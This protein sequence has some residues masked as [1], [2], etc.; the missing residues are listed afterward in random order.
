MDLKAVIKAMLFTPGNGGRWGLPLLFEGAPG[1]GKT[2]ILTEV[3]ASVGLHCEVVIASLREPADFLGLPVPDGD[4]AKYLPPAWAVRAAQAKHAVVFL[5]ELNTAPPA[6]QAALLR[7][8]NERAIGEMVLPPTVRF[9]AAQ[10]KTEDAAGGWDLAAPMAN[11]FG[12]LPWTSP[13]IQQWSSWLVA[14]SA[15]APLVAEAGNAA[16][17][18]E[19]ESVL[20]QWEKPFAMAKGLVAG[21]LR[22]RGD[23]LHK[24]PTSTDPTASKA[25][26]S[27]RT[28][29]MATRAMASA[30]VHKLAPTDEDDLI[31]AF[32][33]NGAAGELLTFRAAADLPDP[34]DL[35]DGKIK[36]EHDPRRLDRTCAV[37]S[38]CAAL[39]SSPAA[40]KRDARAKAM[41]NLMGDVVTKH[42]DILVPATLALVDS[43]LTGMK[44]ARNVLAAMLPVLTAAG[45]NPSSR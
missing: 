30:K 1:V 17:E 7:C 22:S 3:A 31:A 35:L 18:L 45:I 34:E 21:F 6:V 44:E 20:S 32:V 24:Q 8:V 2:A 40:A 14:S 26:P 41:W 27:P 29:E 23:L 38:S 43:H 5:D 42:A 10:N 13:D 28:W 15:L 39:L 12:H 25:W 19:E 16:A 4:R 11:R 36:F 9:L 37:Y 33:G